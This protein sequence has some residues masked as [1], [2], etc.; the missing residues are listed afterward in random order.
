MSR[1]AAPPPGAATPS[2]LPEDPGTRR[3]PRRSLLLT[4]V[5]M[6]IAR[7]HIRVRYETWRLTHGV[8]ALLVAGLALD[9]ALG[10]GRPGYWPARGPRRAWSG[11][12]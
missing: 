4:L 12:P 2:L 6:A 1:G 3:R 10:A 9:H 11:S 8:G 5:V 7:A